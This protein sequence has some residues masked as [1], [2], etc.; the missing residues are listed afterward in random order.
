MI[1]NPAI[2]LLVADDHHL[3]RE[4]LSALFASQ[5]DMQIVGE[6]VDGREAVAQFDALTPDILLLDLQ[7]PGLNGLDV[8]AAIKRRHPLARIIVLTTYEGD[9]L[10]SRAINSG[11]QAYLLKSAVRRELL[12][13]IRAVYRGQKHVQ[14]SVVEGI[15]EHADETA[16]TAREIQVLS[17][18]A[19]G[20]SNKRVADNLSISEE[21]VKGHVKSI[22]AKLRAHDR[23]H[24]V[25]LAVK[26]GYIELS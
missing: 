9:H 20:N 6:A 25:A 23:T 21:T 24:A 19:A 17:L 11:A 3:I 12:D 14:A 7:M 8:I 18:I 4:G 15:T 1:I 26:R 16:L 13:T 5:G 2:R 22:L 10:A